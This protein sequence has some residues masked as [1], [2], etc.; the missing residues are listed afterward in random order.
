MSWK[1]VKGVYF[2][3]ACFITSWFASCFM[4]LPSYG[5]AILVPHIYRS[6]IQFMM[7]TWLLFPP[8]MYELLFGTK[9]RVCGDKMKRSESSLVIANHRTRLDWMFLW[10][11]T[12]R[13]KWSALLRIILRGDLK[14]LPGFGWGMQFAGYYF[15]S[16]KWASDEQYLTTKINYFN[17]AS[18]PQKLLVFPEGT[19]YDKKTKARSDT[20]GE[21]QGW[22]HLEYLLHPR[23]TGTRVY[24][25]STR[26][27]ERSSHG[28]V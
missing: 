28:S 3:F 8:S 22:P 9:V 2:V 14:H 11:V 7:G 15:L 27:T 5:L 24:A 19:D 18:E 10:S 21:K 6:Y 12:G 25:Y 20:F 13:A 1:V 16:R 23:A 4:I 17:T 26:A